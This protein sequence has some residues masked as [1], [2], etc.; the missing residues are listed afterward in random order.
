MV[1]VL[2]LAV[3]SSKEGWTTSTSPSAVVSKAQLRAMRW[4]CVGILS[5]DTLVALSLGI[6]LLVIPLGSILD[7]LKYEQLTQGS[8]DG[9]ELKL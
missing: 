9:S 8:P 5:S 2:D 6:A 1:G 4:S 3:L 7:T